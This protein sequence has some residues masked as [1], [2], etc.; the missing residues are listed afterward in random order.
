MENLL[1][2]FAIL[3][4]ACDFRR[5]VV[6]KDTILSHIAEPY[7]VTVDHALSQKSLTSK[8]ISLSYILPYIIITILCIFEYIW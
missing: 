6:K 8:N 5:G 1:R 3:F 7:S 2:V 4:G